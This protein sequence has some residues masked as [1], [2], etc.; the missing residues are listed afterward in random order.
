AAV[1]NATVEAASESVTVGESTTI[2]VTLRDALGQP[3]TT[4]GGTVTLASSGGGSIGSVTDN[5][6]GTYTATLTAPTTTGTTTI[7][8]KLDDVD[9]TDDLVITFTAGAPAAYL[10]AL[11]DSMPAASAPVAVTAQLQDQYGNNVP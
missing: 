8:A 5:G 7:T 10:V 3:L 6:N 2:T 1:A 11:S 4:S 9:I